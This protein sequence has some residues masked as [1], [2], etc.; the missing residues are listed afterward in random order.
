MF[1]PLY[2]AHHNQHLEDLPFW[3]GLAAQTGDPVLELGCGTGRVL[4][5]MAVAGHRTIGLDRDPSMLTYLHGNIGVKVQVPPIVFIADLSRFH[6]ADQFQL[7]I[8]PCN[9]FSTLPVRSRRDCLWCVRNQLSAGG[10]FAVSLPN[11]ELLLHLPSRS[12]IELEDEFFHPTTGNPVQVS[13]SWQRTKHAFNVTW[14]YD[15]LFPDGKVEHLVVTTT[16]RMTSVE[17]YLSELQSV[18]LNVTEIF[19]DFDRSAFSSD[20]PHLIILGRN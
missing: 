15:H 11:P 2:D 19:G 16:H 1:P 10:I 6:L 8:L 4:I 14:I 20:S 12:E 18:G 5:P 9:T 13:S 7:I 17:T 3:L